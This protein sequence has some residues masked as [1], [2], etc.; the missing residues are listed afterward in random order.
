MEIFQKRG[1]FFGRQLVWLKTFDQRNRWLNIFLLKPKIAMRS[2]KS[3]DNN[4]D[5]YFQDNV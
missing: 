5:F 1:W 4:F 2:M 3:K